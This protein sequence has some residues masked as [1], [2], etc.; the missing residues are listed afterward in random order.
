MDDLTHSQKIYA[1]DAKA[2]DLLVERHHSAV[3]RFLVQLTRHREDA[4]DLTQISLMR[5]IR[6]A[7][8]YDGR[9][10]LRAWILGIAFHEFTRQ[11]R[12]KAW[13]PILKEF[14]VSNQ[15]MDSVLD[16]EVLLGAL[17]KLKPVARAIFLMHY[18]EDVPIAEMSVILR[19][20]E[21]TI[22]SR[23][24][25]ARQKLQTYLEYGEIVYA[26]KHC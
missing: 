7:D 14:A 18:V 15:E 11:R 26:T 3:F 22:K 1:R 12:K 16:T 4:E 20:P 5:A 19:V 21:G 6:A 23:L 10:S 9:A 17:A 2:I 25:S 13:L 24:H 8:R